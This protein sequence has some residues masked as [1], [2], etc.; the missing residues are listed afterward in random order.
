[1][2]PPSL[3][4][5]RWRG[6]SFSRK[7]RRDLPPFA[8]ARPLSPPAGEGGAKRRMRGYGLACRAFA[9][10]LRDYSSLRS[11]RQHCEELGSEAIQASM[12]PGLLRPRLA[13]AGALCRDEKDP[14]K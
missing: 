4:R 8:F 10:T 14:R 13:T 12:A 3:I 2:A 5:P 1:M 6:D 11:L 7:G 9:R